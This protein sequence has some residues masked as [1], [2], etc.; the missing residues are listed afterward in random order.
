MTALLSESRRLALNRRSEV[1]LA[2][3]SMPSGAS[4]MTEGE[5]RMPMEGAPSEFAA[6]T[7]ACALP[8]AATRVSAPASGRMDS[9]RHCGAGTAIGARVRNHGTTNQSTDAQF[10]RPA[11]SPFRPGW[12]YH[13]TTPMRDLIME[14]PIK[15]SNSG[16]TT[17]IQ[18]WIVD[19]TTHNSRFQ[20][21]YIPKTTIFESQSIMEPPFFNGLPSPLLMEPPQFI[22]SWSQWLMEPPLLNG[23]PSQWLMEPTTIHEKHYGTTGKTI[24][25]SRIE[26]RN[27]LTGQ[28][29]PIQG[30]RVNST[31]TPVSHSNH[32]E[33]STECNH[34]TTLHSRRNNHAVRTVWRSQLHWLRRR[35][36]GMPRREA[37][38]PEG[39]GRGGEGEAGWSTTEW[40]KLPIMHSLQGVPT[41]FGIAI[42]A[43]CVEWNEMSLN[44]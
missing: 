33:H 35:R 8:A 29:S 16:G 13:G 26:R 34:C 31:I 9:K 20:G 25:S 22:S 10:T 41:V 7:A 18:E 36:G 4:D 19:G 21:W 28:S 3:E 24:H 2:P 38:W 39:R 44:I 27:H 11:F 30:H 5:G 37:G 1:A 40:C 42:N 23:H 14:P 43:V 17:L 15:L 32:S 6:S 12:R